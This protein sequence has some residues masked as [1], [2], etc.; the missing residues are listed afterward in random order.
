[1]SLIPQTSIR[2][3]GLKERSNEDLNKLKIGDKAVLTTLTQGK[4][5]VTE[6]S[7]EV[8]IL[9]ILPHEGKTI[10]DIKVNRDP[11]REHSSF[12]N[13]DLLVYQTAD[14]KENQMLYGD[15]VVEEEYS[16]RSS[17]STKILRVN[18]CNEYGKPVDTRSSFDRVVSQTT[19]LTVGDYIKDAIEKKEM[20]KD[21]VNILAAQLET[22]GRLFDGGLVE[23][24]KRT[25]NGDS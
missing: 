19:V 1:M 8:T 21:K 3:S 20:L 24:L 2:F 7:Q 11:S 17:S 18:A 15:Y 5:G 16:R 22:I 13:V 9:N 10:N 6:N 25:L 23:L 14:G 12:D 4:R